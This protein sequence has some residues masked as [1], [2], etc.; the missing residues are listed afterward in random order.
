[1]K[2]IIDILKGTAIGIS[3]IIPGFS[4]GTMAVILGVYERLIGSICDITKKPLIVIKDLWAML[5][6]VIIGVVIA[7]FGVV[8]LI[9]EFPLQTIMLF[10]GMIIGTIPNIYFNIKNLSLREDKKLDLSL[11]DIVTF[12]ICFLIMIILPLINSN[13]LIDELN[14]FVFMFI[15]IM[16]IICA[17]AMMIPGISGSLVLMVFGIYLLILENIN[18]FISMVVSF[19]FENIISPFLVLFIFGLGVLVGIFSISKIIKKQF[20]KRRRTVYCAIFGLLISSVFS[21]IYATVGEYNE[22]INWKDPFVYIISVLMFILGST[23]V[24][25]L[26]KMEK[27]KETN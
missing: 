21:I 13:I 1:M 17:S 26:E 19:N 5:M 18:N 10:V 23:I 9:K 16:G 7:S 14:V 12:I 15:F 25:T 8:Y 20:E 4:G 24:C 22:V 11:L 3:N 2:Y 27:N 6:G